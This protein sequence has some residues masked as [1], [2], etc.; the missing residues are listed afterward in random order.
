[1][2][3]ELLTFNTLK[4]CLTRVLIPAYPQDEGLFIHNIEAS[5][6]SIDAVPF[7]V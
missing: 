4:K 1:M 3:T 7:Q 5:Q 2:E 6:T